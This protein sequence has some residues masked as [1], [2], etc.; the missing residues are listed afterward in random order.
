M[1]REEFHVYGTEAVKE[2]GAQTDSEVMDVVDSHPGL[3]IREIANVLLWQY[4]KAHGSIQRL[5]KNNKVIL[6]PARKQGKLAHLVFPY[7]SAR[8][9]P[10]VVVVDKRILDDP[11]SWMSNHAF[12]YCLTKDSFGITAAPFAQWH[13]SGVPA[14]EVDISETSNSL[15]ILLNKKLQNFYMTGNTEFDV[16]SSNNKIIVSILETYFPISGTKT[17]I[18]ELEEEIEADEEPTSLHSS[19]ERKDLL[20]HAASKNEK[21]N[22][23]VQENFYHPMVEAQPKRRQV[24]PVRI[25]DKRT[26]FRVIEK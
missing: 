2:K 4:G 1:G 24:S 22:E 8:R 10:N 18:G 15:T 9:D 13:E 20:W 6:R 3:D 19:Q 17:E 14:G 5:K 11:K 16:A 7:I 23:L 26:Q 21:W 12:A 25:R